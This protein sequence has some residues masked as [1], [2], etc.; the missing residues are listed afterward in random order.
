MCK[1]KPDMLL[2]SEKTIDSYINRLN[3]LIQAVGSK[4]ISRKKFGLY[5]KYPDGYEG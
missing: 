4:P 5:I 2:Q 1:E 3:D